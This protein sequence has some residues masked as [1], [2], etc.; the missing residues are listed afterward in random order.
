M[1]DLK[2]L[3]ANPELYELELKK[4]NKNPD[5]ASQLSNHNKKLLEENKILDALRQKKNEF[6]DQVI[7]L[8]GEEKSK[9]IIEMQSLSQKIKDQEKLVSEL[10]TIVSETLYKIP[11]LTSDQTPVG[12]DSDSNVVSEYFGTK[13]E[14]SF[15]PKN[16]FDLPVFKRDYLGEKGVE[17]FG[18]R[19]YYIKGDLA[20][21][22]R[23]LYDYILESLVN[24]GFE[25]V[26]P[27]ILVNEK[28]MYGTGFF[29]DGVEDAY[30]VNS[31]DKTFYLVGTSEAPLMYMYSN[32][33]IDLT[34]P[35]L[36][37]AFTPCFRKEAGSYGKDTQGGIRVHQ[38][39]KIETVAICKPEDSAKVFDLL[40]K[41]FTNNIQKLDLHFQHLEVCTGDI[42]IKNN[43]QVDIEAWFPAQKQYR[44]LASSSN[45]T[46]Y[47]TRTLGI[48][49]IDQ[50]G[51]KAIAHSLNC[52]GITNRAL[53]A[54][55]E[56]FQQEDGSVLIPEELAKRTGKNI[57]I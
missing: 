30:S 10:K 12:K 23:A 51:N 8:S 55:L 43:R 15:E 20:I 27:P 14:M 17:A 7:K 34:E 44:E 46:D 33:T 40:T 11:N 41:T 38:F 9:S 16:Y 48:T 4:R 57:L 49:F 39:D 21:L 2:H 3:T 6:N 52:T 56:Q 28:T 37:T 45:C 19:G 32:S 50:D 26:I 1:I 13:K 22:Q 42:S 54:L 25:Y 31:S 5:L 29:P 24:S 47:Q 18:S 36:L 35:V 53:F